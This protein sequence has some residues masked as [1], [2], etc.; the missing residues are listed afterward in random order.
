M[1]KWMFPT[2]QNLG[3]KLMRLCFNIVVGTSCC[4]C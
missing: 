4:Q 3:R 2:R 1:L